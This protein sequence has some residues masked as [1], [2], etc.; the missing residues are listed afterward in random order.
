MN[1]LEAKQLQKEKSKELFLP[2]GI[3]LAVNLIHAFINNNNLI[4]LKIAILLSGARQQ[5]KYDKNN[6]VVFS[7]DELCEI[8]KTDRKELSRG[9]KKITETYYEYVLADGTA[10]GTRPIHTMEYTP[11]KKSVRFEISSRAK[12]LFT[13]LGKGKYQFARDIS[14]DNLMCLKHKHALRMQLFLEMINNYSDGV[15]KR[16]RMTLDEANGYF[17]TNYK[18]FYELDR[19]ILKPIKSEISLVN[20]RTFEYFFQEEKNRGTG[21]PKFE[22]VV[23]DVIDNSQSL[24]AQ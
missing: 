15:G 8:I 24:F 6:S 17:G 7:V 19:K 14:S 20:K 12:E 22:Y 1:P 4:G 3:E 23:I 5:I 16:K 18:N 10:G 21:R 2:K 13:E 11:D 9:K